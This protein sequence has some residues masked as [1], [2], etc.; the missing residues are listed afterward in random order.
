M[1]VRS[2]KQPKSVISRLAWP[3]QSQIPATVAKVLLKVTFNDNDIDRINSLSRKAQLGTLSVEEQAELNEYEMVGHF[4]S[5]MHLK[6]KAS[7]RPRGKAA[8]N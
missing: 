6:A 4:L 8:T 7:L 1:A 3:S 2:K 5:I